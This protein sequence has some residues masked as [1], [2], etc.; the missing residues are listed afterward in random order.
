[1]KI[2][3]KNPQFFFIIKMLAIFSVLYFGSQFWIGITSKEN[4]YNQFIDQNLNYIK[5][6]RISILNGASVL[7][8]LLGY[9]TQIENN[10]SLQVINGYKINMVY[11]CI[12][13]GIFSSWAAFIIAF[14]N[15]KIKQ[16]LIW[17][18]TGLLIVW[19]LN[20][21]RVSTLLI[22]VNKSRN[23]NG[24]NSHHTIYNTIAYFVILLLIYIYTNK[25]SKQTDLPINTNIS[26]TQIK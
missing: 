4:Y 10:I 7:C 17:L 15:K 24:F 16:K 26:S 20:V 23:I 9:S 8:K 14:P 18:F 5:W 6:L 2:F 25:V 12:G 21:I 22:L 13:I 1:M 3:T 11:S 19:I